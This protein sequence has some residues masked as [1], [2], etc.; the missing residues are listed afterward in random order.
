MTSVFEEFSRGWSLC[1]RRGRSAWKSLKNLNIAGGG[2]VYA[3]LRKGLA[4]LWGAAVPELVGR[5][6]IA[7]HRRNIHV[8]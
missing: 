5:A 4:P 2:G 3:L 6:M 8:R 1:F 7:K